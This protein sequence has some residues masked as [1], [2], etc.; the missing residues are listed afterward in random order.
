MAVLQLTIT[1]INNSFLRN[2]G[3]ISVTINLTNQALPPVSFGPGS[4]LDGGIAQG[5]T[6][7]FTVPVPA[8]APAQFQS[9][10][11]T[12]HPNGG[13]D[14]DRWDATITAA[15][16][17]NTVALPFSCQPAMFRQATPAF[18]MMAPNGTCNAL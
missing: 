14:E 1:S 6:K 4:G 2:G 16:I 9:V 3:S 12:Y 7:I 18:E 17:P 15:F 10:I 8:S 5:E 13:I 11:V